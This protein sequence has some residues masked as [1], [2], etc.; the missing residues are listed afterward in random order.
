M[1]ISLR[2]E[3]S[4]VPAIRGNL[5]QLIVQACT[6]HALGMEI[7]RR[8]SEEVETSDYASPEGKPPL[9]CSLLC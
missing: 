1:Y 6:A 4:T 5:H 8:E 2:W 7:R 3:L 9:V